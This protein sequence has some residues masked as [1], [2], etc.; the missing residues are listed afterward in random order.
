ML[1]IR[2]FRKSAVIRAMVYGTLT[3]VIGVLLFI[4]VL[5]FPPASTS[6]NGDVIAVNEQNSAGDDAQKEQFYAQQHGVFST[7]DGATQFI[8]GYPMLNKASIVKVDEQYFVW[9]KVVN[10]KNEVITPTVPASFHKAFTLTSS[11]PQTELQQL[12]SV[13][14]NE[15]WL[16]NSFEE[17]QEM[18]VLPEGWEGLVVEVSKLSTDLGVV[19][20]HALS[21]YYEQ[22]ECLKITF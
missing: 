11:C 21:H 16:N 14:K 12:P 6:D 7:H 5:Q 3:G 15:K 1:F 4:F 19:R 17:Q 8:A 22:L 9:S 18:A 10:D 20:L 13:L 2:S